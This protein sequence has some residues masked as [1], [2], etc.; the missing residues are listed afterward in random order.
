MPRSPK[1]SCLTKACKHFALLTCMTYDLTRSSSF[2]WLPSQYSPTST[3]HELVVLQ[4]LPTCHF[5][6]HT[7]KYPPQEPLFRHPPSVF[8][9]QRKLHMILCFM[10]FNVYILWHHTGRQNIWNW[11]LASISPNFIF[12]KLLYSWNFESHSCIWIT[13][14]WSITIWHGE[15]ITGW[16]PYVYA[17]LKALP[18][19]RCSTRIILL[20]PVSLPVINLETVLHIPCVNIWNA[21]LT[22]FDFLT[23]RVGTYQ[24]I[25]SHTAMALPCF[26]LHIHNHIHFKFWIKKYIIAKY[27]LVFS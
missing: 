11:I 26:F 23:C 3:S 20:Q 24:Y 16:L 13:Q 15:M 8:H 6:Y 25:V 27:I 18:T 5:L 10:Y 19:D 9:T 4:F 14:W 21:I 2:S 12:V 1:W 7:Y 17:L 22:C